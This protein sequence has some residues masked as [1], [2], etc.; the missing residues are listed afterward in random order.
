[1]DDNYDDEYTPL[2]SREFNKNFMLFGAISSTFLGIGILIYYV[3]KV[4]ESHSLPKTG[5]IMSLTNFGAFGDFIGGFIGTL[6]SLAGIFFLY[7]TLKEQRENFNK[8]RL[9]NNFFEM[10]KFHRENVN[11]LQFTYYENKDTIV[12]AE[13]RKVFKIIYSQFKDLWNELNFVFE[14]TNVESI[15]SEL[16]L[17]E[18]KAKNIFKDYKQVAQIDIVYLIIF[19]GLGK[20]DLIT[21]KTLLKNKYDDQF[22]ENIIL[23]AVLKPKKESSY[24]KKWE[25]INSINNIEIK[26]EVIKSFYN[27]RDDIFV[28][29]PINNLYFN[30]QGETVFYKDNYEKFY[31]GH[32]FRLGHYYRNI[33]QNIN[34]INS[35]IYLTYDEKY[36]YIKLLRVHFS[37]YEQILLFLNSISSIGRNWELNN[38]ENANKKLITKYN[39]I[40]NIPNEQI[41]D[42]IAI[43]DYYP[44]INYEVSITNNLKKIKEN[45]KQYR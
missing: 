45:I 37:N 12:T 17:K 13:K 24:W 2:E 20:E 34:F 27:E 39:L 35:Q 41:I 42:S 23:V 21:I 7:L 3:V 22:I 28:L 43:K 18:L 1:M 10:I 32:Q 36:S 40:K 5:Q 8:E 11:E 26:N 14:S 33:F 29:N 30:N 38:F 25:R 4:T 19:F 16:H 44:L 15:Y 9:E 6:F 31:G